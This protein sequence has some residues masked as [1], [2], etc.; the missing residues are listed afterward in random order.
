PSTSAPRSRSRRAITS[1]SLIRG[2]LVRTHS[3]V[4]S[5]HAASSGS[6]A[7]LLPSTWT[8][9]D[10]RWPPSIRSVDMRMA[11]LVQSET[12]DLLAQ[13]DAESFTDFGP[14]LVDQKPDLAGRG[15]AVVHDEVA[16]RRRH[17]RAA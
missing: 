2:T 3:S 17:A 12:H 4:V 15:V 13:L 6:A 9:P 5:R 10:S 11:I 16:V 7:F 14:A 1:T 8:E